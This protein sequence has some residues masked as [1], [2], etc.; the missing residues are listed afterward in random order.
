MKYKKM[1]LSVDYVNDFI[2]Y[3]INDLK[4]NIIGL[5]CIPPVE[6]RS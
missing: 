2:N 3:C 5:M 1:E 6:C 4:L